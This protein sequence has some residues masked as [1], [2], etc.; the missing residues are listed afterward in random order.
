[1]VSIS[2]KPRAYTRAWRKLGHIW[3]S[4]CRGLGN[5]VDFSFLG[6]PHA[7]DEFKSVLRDTHLLSFL[8][9]HKG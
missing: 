1:M 4:S 5:F 7:T 9:R 3:N 6:P 2:S 8:G